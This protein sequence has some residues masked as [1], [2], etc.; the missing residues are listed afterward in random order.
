MRTEEEESEGDRRGE[1]KKGAKGDRGR[2]ERRRQ[3]G[4]KDK[5][6]ERAVD[7]AASHLAARGHHS[8]RLK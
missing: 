4:D 7:S 1:E 5:S 3:E 8:H 2:K 6:K